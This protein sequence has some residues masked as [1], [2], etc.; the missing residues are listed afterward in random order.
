MLQYLSAVGDVDGRVVHVPVTR[1][2]AKPSFLGTK[3]QLHQIV[4]F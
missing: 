2:Q 1:P 3:S 4:N